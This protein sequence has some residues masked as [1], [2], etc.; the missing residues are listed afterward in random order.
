MRHVGIIESCIREGLDQTLG[1]ISLLPREVVTA[2]CL[3]SCKEASYVLPCPPHFCYECLLRCAECKPECPLCKR[4]MQSI[5][6]L[7]WADNDYQEHSLTLSV[8]PSDFV[9][10][11]Q[12]APTDPDDDDLQGH[13]SLQWWIADEVP[14]YLVNILQHPNW[15]NA[16]QTHP[17]LLQT[18]QSWFHQETEETFGNGLLQ[19]AMVQDTFPGIHGMNT[20][21]LVWM[22]GS[23]SRTPVAPALLPPEEGLPAPDQP[24]VP[25]LPHP[26]GMS[27]P[28][29]HPLLLLAVLEDT[30]LLL[31]PSPWSKKS[32][33]RSQGRLCPGH[34]LPTGS[35]IAPLGRYGDPGR[36]GP[37]GPRALRPARG[38]HRLADPGGCLGGWPHQDWAIC[39]GLH[40]PSRPPSPTKSNC[41]NKTSAPKLQKKSLCS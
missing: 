4:G 8:P 5:L 30:P 29:P 36:G 13:G 10:E 31:L 21:L 37:A 25:A 23:P 12:P 1:S 18:L 27:F 6:H 39:W 33:R 26:A 38:W 17:V 20:K 24:P 7:V 19:T 35:G 15:L 2:P 41:P 22:L 40:R 3:G 28:S 9:G 32:P 14:R 34:P 16:F 11:A